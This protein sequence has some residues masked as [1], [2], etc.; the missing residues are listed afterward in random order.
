MCIILVE[1]Q[2]N[3]DMGIELV[4]APIHKELV[5]SVPQGV[6]KRYFRTIPAIITV[7][8]LEVKLSLGIYPYVFR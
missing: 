7:C 2:A 6:F 4:K 1:E 5:C 3:D 8:N